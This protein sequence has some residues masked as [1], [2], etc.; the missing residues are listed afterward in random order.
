MTNIMWIG[1]G[2]VLVT[3]AGLLISRDWRIALGLLGMQYVGAFWLTT[4]HWPVSMAAIKLVTGWMAIT[5]LGMTRLNV[6]NEEDIGTRFWPQGRLFRLFASGVITVIVIT[7]APGIEDIIP[8]IGLPVIT[9]SLILIGLG[10][11][12]LGM[13]ANAFRI[14]LGLLTVLSGF[15]VLYAA[16]ESSVLVAAMLSVV[17]LGLA[18]VGAYL[19]SAVNQ[20][21]TE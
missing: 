12:H 8:G 5:T 20:G 1:V 3:S 9:S 11:L 15:E 21:E 13:S 17:N 4:Q 10:I 16:L 19:L 14:S 2:L 6:K 18:L 7:L